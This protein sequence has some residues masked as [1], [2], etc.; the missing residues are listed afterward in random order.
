MANGGQLHR[1]FEGKASLTHTVVTVVSLSAR[2]L[3]P[4]TQHHS[5]CVGVSRDGE[6]HLSCVHRDDGQKKGSRKA[7]EHLGGTRFIF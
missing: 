1:R 4:I 3:C 5:T 2:A 6:S 7:D